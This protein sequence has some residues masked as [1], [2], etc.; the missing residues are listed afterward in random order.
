[1]DL[2]IPDYEIKEDKYIINIE[3][4]TT[5][6][7]FSTKMNTSSNMVFKKDGKQL[8][9]K[10]KI[11]T[12]TEFTIENSIKYMLVVT[13][14]ITGDG[15]VNISDLVKLNMYSVGKFNLQNEY[16]LAGDVNHDRNVNIGDLVRLN[17]FSIG[18]I[19]SL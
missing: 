5:V 7:E 19:N 2:Q 16:L 13:G 3:P 11:S 9:N 18:K 4:N 17:L 10:Q 14:D 8:S 6:E 12:G 1:M 15:N